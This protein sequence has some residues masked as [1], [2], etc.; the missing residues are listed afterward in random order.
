MPPPPRVGSTQPPPKAAGQQRRGSRDQRGGRG[1]GHSNG[2][3]EYDHIPTIHLLHRLD[4]LSRAV[5]DD[6]TAVLNLDPVPSSSLPPPSPMMIRPTATTP[7]EPTSASRRSNASSMVMRTPIGSRR[8]SAVEL[9]PSASNG[10]TGFRS[11]PILMSP[12]PLRPQRE[13]SASHDDR[14]D[15]SPTLPSGAL[16]F[17]ISPSKRSSTSPTQPAVEVAPLVDLGG[18]S[19]TGERRGSASV[20]RSPISPA[21]PQLSAVSGSSANGRNGYVSNSVQPKGSKLEMLLAKL[22]S[23]VDD[24]KQHNENSPSRGGAGAAAVPTAT[25]GKPARKSVDIIQL[26]LE[27]DDEVASGMPNGANGVTVMDF[28]FN[29]TS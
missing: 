6:I 28:N 12:T 19:R 13:G 1:A 4:E 26:E 25:T 15:P 5:I 23:A 22:G 10:P 11:A 24:A 2:S 9:A 21:P 8:G 16:K 18:S 27:D 14:R 3:G 17:S 20:G 29:A 7:V